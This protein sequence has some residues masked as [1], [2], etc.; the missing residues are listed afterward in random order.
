M[1]QFWKKSGQ[2]NRVGTNL[3]GSNYNESLPQYVRPS[4]T[5]ENF[6]YVQISEEILDS[7]TEVNLKKS[8]IARTLPEILQDKN[9][10]NHFIQFMESRES[11]AY[12]LCWLDI[13]TFKVDIPKISSPISLSVTEHDSL[14]VST[15]SDS[16]ISSVS[17]EFSEGRGS[18]LGKNPNHNCDKES[19]DISIS[20]KS[21]K[22]F[23]EKNDLVDMDLLTRNALIIFKKYIAQ[24]AI[25]NIKCND[26]IRKDL[27]ENICDNTKLISE[28]CFSKVQNHVYNMMDKEYFESFLLSDFYCKY[29]IDVLTSGN[30]VLYDILSNETALFY[31]MEYLEQ[32][33][34]RHLLE[35]W[36][37]ATNFQQQLKNQG[38][39][40]DPVEAQN[41][42]VVLYD[43]YFSLQA[44][45]PLGLGDKVR[46]SLEQKICGENGVTLDSFNL[47]ISIVEKILEKYFIQPFLESQLFYKFLSELI[48]TVQSNG[49]ATSI[50]KHKRSPSDGDSEHSFASSTFLAMEMNHNPVKK[51]TKASA[52]MTIDTR[53]LYDP[54]S[55]WKQRRKSRLLCGHVNDLGR[56]ETEFEPE[57][58][59]GQFNLKDVVR[60]FVSLEEEQKRKEE[61]AWQV[62]EMIVRDITNITLNNN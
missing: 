20:P 8:S 38:E 60:K 30:I 22:N 54:D 35:F 14:S 61:M 28:N 17:S 1:L 13:E 23:K 16:I 48:N 19:S 52:D 50:Q 51:Y 40:F 49:Y 31:F 12:V 7:G 10:V 33:D 45:C 56:F 11:E 41:D 55:L 3:L 24:E 15:D 34:Q 58:D 43:K 29:Q 62:A 36:M 6:E 4:K 2:K 9:A 25:L 27:I 59:R 46:L 32:E 47:A 37:A 57:P 39:F 44:L 42:A 21:Y 53:E 26:N 5:T 18:N